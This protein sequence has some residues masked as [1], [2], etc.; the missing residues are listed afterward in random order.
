MQ[1]TR[2]EMS[3]EGKEVVAD[4]HFL[5][6]AHAPSLACPATEAHTHTDNT[7]HP[8]KISESTPDTHAVCVSAVAVAVANEKRK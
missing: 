1:E 5:S 3:E 2:D 6:S 8:Q 7:H 4:Q